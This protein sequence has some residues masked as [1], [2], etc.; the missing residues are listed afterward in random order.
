MFN[1]ED[2]KAL[3]GIA[4]IMMMLHHLVA[5][6]DRYPKEFEGFK[7]LWEGFVTEGYLGNLSNNV[8]LCVAIFFFLGGYGMYKQTEKGKYSLFNSVVRLF[9]NYWKVFVIFVPIAFIFFRRSGEDICYLSTRYDVQDVKSLI[10]T[11]ISNFFALSSSINSEW[12]FIQTYICVMLLGSVYCTLLRKNKYFAVELFI[13]FIIDILVRSFFPALKSVEG[14]NML[15]N[16]FFYNRLL[17]LENPAQCFFAGITFAKFDAVVKIKKKLSE[18]PFSTFIS[19]LG[20][21]AVMW[22][23]G[24]VLGD[25]FDIVYAI[26]F[27]VTVSQFF[28]G[29]KPVKKIFGYLGK[30][31]TN[32]WLIHSFFCYYFLEVTKIVYITRNVWIDLLI[33]TVMSL[34]AS[35]IVDFIFKWISVFYDKFK[36]WSTAIT[37]PKVLKTG[38]K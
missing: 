11:V 23:R 20:V 33:L 1:R 30:H 12:W 19:L 2:T 35:I 36:I 15:G 38:N 32:I 14:L 9:R 25:L 31:S 37:N 13:V 27:T 4:V 26:A 10:T 34:A 6:S 3:K 21:F 16:N 8:R 5:F 28:D 7:S 18:I 29:V 22:C 17:I 24:F